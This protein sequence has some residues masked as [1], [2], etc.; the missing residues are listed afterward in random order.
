MKTAFIRAIV[1]IACVSLTPEA[2]AIEIDGLV[3]ASVTNVGH[4][5]EAAV[6]AFQGL[7]LFLVARLASRTAV[8]RASARPAGS[9]SDGSTRPGL[10]P[11]VGPSAK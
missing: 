10:A 5:P 6:I 9:C 2:Y 11:V 1:G 4:V 8:H 3:P 7:V